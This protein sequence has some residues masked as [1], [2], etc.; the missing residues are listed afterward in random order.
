MP[1]CQLDHHHHSQAL[2]FRPPAG[3]KNAW[4]VLIAAKLRGVEVLETSALQASA[5]P[6]GRVSGCGRSGGGELCSA[7]AFCA[8]FPLY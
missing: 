6:L 5:H 4:K 7:G 3:N 8:C 1:G 2:L